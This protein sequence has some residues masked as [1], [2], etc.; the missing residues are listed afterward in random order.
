MSCIKE[1]PAWHAMLQ[2]DHNIGMTLAAGRLVANQTV[3]MR[4]PQN[5]FIHLPCITKLMIAQLNMLVHLLLLCPHPTCM[6]NR[7]RHLLD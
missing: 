7:E 2:L 3:R 4:S 1:Q 5:S 6:Q